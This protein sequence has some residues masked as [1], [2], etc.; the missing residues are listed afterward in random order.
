MISTCSLR[1]LPLTLLFASCLARVLIWVMWKPSLNL[2]MIDLLAGHLKTIFSINRNHG[3]C[4]GATR[5]VSV[6]RPEPL[7]PA[8]DP[9][10]VTQS[11]GICPDSQVT[12]PCSPTRYPTGRRQ[13][14]SDFSPLAG[15]MIPAFGAAAADRESS[16]YPSLFS[17]VGCNSASSDGTCFSLTVYSAT[18]LSPPCPCLLSAVSSPSALPPPCPS[19]RILGQGRAD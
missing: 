16:S 13:R 3:W 12:G 7:G 14:G 9:T 8:L 15:W 11:T 6:D 5:P 1:C 18:A 19:L 17:L 10:L 2:A 4:S